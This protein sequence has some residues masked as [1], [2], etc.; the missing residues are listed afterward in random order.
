MGLRID[1]YV[2]T[3]SAN[4]NLSGVGALITGAKTGKLQGSMVVT[5]LGIDGKDIV[6]LLPL[7]AE[8]DQTSI[9]NSIQAHSSVKALMWTNDDPLLR[10]TPLLF[11]VKQ[12]EQG[13]I[14]KLQSIDNITFGGN[15]ADSKVITKFTQNEKGMIDSLKWEKVTEILNDVRGEKCADV[16]NLVNDMDCACFRKY[17]IQKLNEVEK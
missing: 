5:V 16:A 12:D 9:Q 7:C 2:E 11:A 4:V 6:N 8:I 3:N 13:A 14:K 10:I 1:A 17:V 15:D